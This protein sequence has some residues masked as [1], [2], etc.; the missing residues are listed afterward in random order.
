MTMAELIDE[1]MRGL[2]RLGVMHEAQVRGALET[3]AAEAKNTLEPWQ[4]EGRGPFIHLWKSQT[5]FHPWDAKT[6]DIHIEDIAWGLSNE[7]RFG[8]QSPWLSVAEHSLNVSALMAGHPTQSLNHQLVG[9]LHDA[10][11]AYLKDIPTPI[12]HTPA[13]AEYRALEKQ[14][15]VTVFERFHLDATEGTRV[16]LGWADKAMLATEKHE[17]FPNGHLAMPGEVLPEARRMRLSRYSPQIVYNLFMQRYTF[18]IESQD[19]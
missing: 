5:K 2:Y 11:E 4:F 8:G 3:I 1:Q 6:E 13:F 17:L 10:A 18:L 19:L 9:L 16:L 7:C 14:L 12:K 15:Q